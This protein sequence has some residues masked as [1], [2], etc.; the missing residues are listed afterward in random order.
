MQINRLFCHNY[1]NGQKE[2]NPCCCSISKIKKFSI[3]VLALLC[4]LHFIFFPLATEYYNDDCFLSPEKYQAVV[5][6][7]FTVTSLLIQ[8]NQTFWL[9]YGTLLGYIRKQKILPYDSDADLGRIMLNENEE[10]IFCETFRKRL[11]TEEMILADDCSKVFYTNKYGN[12]VHVDLFR[13]K[14]GS[15]E[16]RNGTEVKY[17]KR[18]DA[19]EKFE[20]DRLLKYSKRMGAGDLPV[21]LVLPVK[22]ATM[23]KKPVK[24][25]KMPK[26]VIKFRYPYS[27]KVSFPYKW[28]CW[29][30]WMFP[31]KPVDEET[32]SN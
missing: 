26:D 11:R 24:V 2:D 17:L 7:V 3:G 13:W 19:K 20:K 4:F 28:K 6:A 9:D 30:P 25:P 8:Y 32:K 22:E 29:L 27:H 1:G 31:G 5:H 21:N 14:I 12:V 16:N 18:I 15:S 23:M 10:A